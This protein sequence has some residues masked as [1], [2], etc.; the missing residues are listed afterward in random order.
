MSRMKRL[1][2][3]FGA[4]NEDKR[5]IVMSNAMHALWSLRGGEHDDLY[6]ACEDF[7][8]GGELVYDAAI[9]AVIN[10]WRRNGR[11]TLPYGKIN[12]ELW[13]EHEL[14]ESDDTALKVFGDAIQAYRDRLEEEGT[15]KEALREKRK[16][17]RKKNKSLR[18]SGFKKAWVKAV[19]E[20][21]SPW[22]ITIVDGDNEME[23]NGILTALR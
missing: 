3:R 11:K 9:E 12:G 23:F 19:S 16:E 7:H 18:M 17:A 6:R 2:E 22:V 15:L 14:P 13:F 8:A 1:Y 5:W 21:G 10:G 20:K 4:D